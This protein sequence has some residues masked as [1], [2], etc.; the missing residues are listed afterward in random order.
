MIIT[1]VIITIITT[2]I[3]KKCDP[4]AEDEDRANNEYDINVGHDN[5]Q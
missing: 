1:M 5:Y 3:K 4:Y 2:I